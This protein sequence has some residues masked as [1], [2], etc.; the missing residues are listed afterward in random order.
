MK[1]L[2]VLSSLIMIFVSNMN[3]AFASQFVPDLAYE[4]KVQVIQ[5][6][7]NHEMVKHTQSNIDA[8]DIEVNSTNLKGEKDWRVT[9]TTN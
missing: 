7:L 6:H 4:K 9:K 5:S 1:K 3:I 8:N 2:S